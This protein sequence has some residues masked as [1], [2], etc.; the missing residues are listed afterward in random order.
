MALTDR[1]LPLQLPRQQRTYS[2]VTPYDPLLCRLALCISSTRLMALTDWALTRCKHSL[3]QLDT[4]SLTRL[5]K[6]KPVLA[7]GE[8]QPLQWGFN[9]TSQ[10]A[11]L[12]RS[13]M[14]GMRAL[15]PGD[16]QDPRR[17]YHRRNGEMMLAPTE[18]HRACRSQ[19][20]TLS[21]HNVRMP[22][23]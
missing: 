16:L 21:E 12:T 19:S 8:I 1:V 18:M 2:R 14:K 9:T 7:S 13:Q 23:S 5:G 22:C 15:D 17:Q 6:K 3:N 4:S 10:Q 20:T 11:E